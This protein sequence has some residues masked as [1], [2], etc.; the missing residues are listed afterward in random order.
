[1]EGTIREL[2]VK[3]LDVQ[4]KKL[5][6]A[7]RKLAQRLLKDPKLDEAIHQLVSIRRRLTLNNMTLEQENDKQK[8]A[9][10]A[11]RTDTSRTRTNDDVKK[12]KAPV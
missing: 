2:V 1:M 5:K 12:A 7:K 8:I 10:E 9:K 4:I 6:A 3:R 11:T